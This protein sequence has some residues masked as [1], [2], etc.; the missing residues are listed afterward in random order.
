MRTWKSAATLAVLLASPVWAGTVFNDGLIHNISDGSLSGCWIDVHSGPRGT[1]TTL[2]VL[3]G[4]VLDSG[5]DASAIN[6]PLG[7]ESIINISGGT[8]TGNF[9]AVDCQ[10]AG[11]HSISGGMIS[12][13]T[14]GVILREGAYSISG[15][16]I[17]GPLPAWFRT[18]AVVDF[19]GG[20]LDGD[21]GAIVSDNAQLNVHSGLMQSV[22]FH[23]VTA[24][25]NSTTHIYGGTMTGVETSGNATL[26]IHGGTIT[27]PA[28]KPNAIVVRNG[29]VNIRGGDIHGN[30]TSGGVEL[31]TFQG[32][33]SIYGTNF[34]HPVGPLPL[35]DGAIVSGTLESGVAF[36][37]RYSNVNGGMIHLIRSTVATKEFTLGAVKAMYLGTAPLPPVPRP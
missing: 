10:T 27:A 23:A 15:G 36:S 33:V 4:A 12:G 21:G 28:G 16:V 22:N 24:S 29:I 1:A 17:S 2:N 6:S 3:P 20:T 34:D 31:I 8:I 25:H 37:W 30:T 14:Y 13:G 19:I 18:N 26:T 5:L 11:P 7:E 35:G 9:V 32:T